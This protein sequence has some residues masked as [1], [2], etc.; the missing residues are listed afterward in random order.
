MK[1]RA[2][3]LSRG[4]GPLAGR[5]RRGR[6]DRQSYQRAGDP[7]PRPQVA[8]C[9]GAWLAGSTLCAAYG[10]TTGSGALHNISYVCSY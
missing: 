10:R 5:D 3:A 1:A 4:C 8:I 9:C 2:C 7:Q 6:R